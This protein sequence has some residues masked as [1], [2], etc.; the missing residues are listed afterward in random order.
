MLNLGGNS[1]TLTILLKGKDEFSKVFE[2]ANSKLG[3]FQGTLN[4]V[5]IASTAAITAISGIA[6]GIGV[7]AVKGAIEFETAMANISTLVDTSTESMEKMKEEVLSL[8]EEMPIKISDLTSA[9]YQVR[10]AGI[11]ASEAMNVLE[12]SAKLGVAGLGTTE[13]ATDLLTSAFNVFEKQGL[14]ANQM[15]DVLF[16]TVKAGKT[17]VSELAQSFGMVAPI[18]GEMDIRLEELQAATAALTTTGMKASVAQS[19][20]RAGLVAMLKPTEDMSSL[21]TKIGVSTGRELIQTSGGLVEAFRLIREAAEGDDEAIAKAFGSVEALNSA[22][23]LTSGSVGQVYL[24][25]IESMT[26]E[27]DLLNE[28]FLKQKETFQASMQIINNKLN[29]ALIQLGTAIMPALKSAIDNIVLPALSRLSGWFDEHGDGI[30]SFFG[31]VASALELLGEEGGME[32]LEDKIRS[33]IPGIE[34]FDKIWGSFGEPNK[35]SMNPLN[36]PVSNK[37][38]MQGGETDIKGGLSINFDFKGAF[39]GDKEQFKNEVIASINRE[40][41]L[42]YAGA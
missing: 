41:T 8:S 14:S 3:G 26:G 34:T 27:T 35:D 20:L 29:V 2:S 19:Q 21:F 33:K 36:W 30:I 24:N 6:I 32:K 5:K 28:A 23:A 7:K 31:K 22:L 16:K 42:K 12:A 40:S 13:E 25:T 38:T 10:S 37:G 39:I 11:S 18:A 1:E 17:T 15:A 9:L 4:K